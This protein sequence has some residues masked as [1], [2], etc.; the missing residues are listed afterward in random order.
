MALQKFLSLVNGVL[1]L[2][3]SIDSSAGETDAGK[4][5]A[6]DST[7][8]LDDTML[9]SGIGADVLVA[10]ASENLAAGDYVNLWDDTGT[11]KARKAN[12]TDNTKPA[13]GFVKAGFSSAANA[14]VYF[15][16]E[17]D[18]L[19]GLTVGTKYFLS[20]TG[21]AATATAPSTTGNVVQYLGMAHATTKIRFEPERSIEIA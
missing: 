1:T 16:G 14:T 11:V 19:T 3:T 15:E 4:L 21:G 13:H 9:P 7:G 2:N 6:L 8:K 18:S 17:N 12:A 5:I 20:A 10:P